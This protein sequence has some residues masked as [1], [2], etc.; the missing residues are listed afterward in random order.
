VVGNVAIVPY[1]RGEMLAA[2]E[3][4]GSGD[5]TAT[6]KL[7]DR[8]V[9]GGDVPTPAVTPD[10]VVTLGDRGN[11]PCL[12]TGTGEVIWE[13]QLPKSRSKYYSSPVLAGDL[14]YCLRDDGVLFIGQT[15]DEFKLLDEHQFG[16]QCV[17]TPVAIRD[18]L[19]IRG[20]EHLFRIALSLPDERPREILGVFSKGAKQPSVFI[21]SIGEVVPINDWPSCRTNSVCV[22]SIRQW[23]E[24][25]R[26]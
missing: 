15:G 13:D 4:S 20:R 8:P 25:V 3:V 16:E 23:G 17:A 11:L 1:L 7:W 24:G 2:V 26:M 18:G 9:K 22:A 10:R 6:A 12:A 14:V 5:I 21:Q 19:L